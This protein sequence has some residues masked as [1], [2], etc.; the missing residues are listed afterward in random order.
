[1]TVVPK[2]TTHPNRCNLFKRLDL[3]S[4]PGRDLYEVLE[5][6]RTAT[7]DEIKRSYRKVGNYF[8]V[9]TDYL[10]LQ[11]KQGFVVS[12]TKSFMEFAFVLHK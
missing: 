7:D 6:P 9:S 5:V 3:C 2:T 1:M 12:I 8:A 10:P 11:R 4:A